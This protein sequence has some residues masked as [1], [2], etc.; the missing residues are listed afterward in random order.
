MVAAYAVPSISPPDKLS[1]EEMDV[2]TCINPYKFWL[3]LAFDLAVIAGVIA[4]NEYF[5]FNPLVY[6]FT[7]L[8]ISSRLHAFAVLMHDCAHQRAFTSKRLNEIVGEPLAW[9]VLFTREGYRNNHLA[10]HQ[11]LNTM[12]D[13]DW[14]RK[15]SYGPFTF[16]KTKPALAREM[17]RQ[18]SGGGFAWFILSLIRS[19]VT[20]DIS[21]TVKRYRLLFYIA[22][23]GIC[24]ATGTLGRLVLYW[25][26]PLATVFN[27]L[28]YQRSV[29]EHHGNMEY[30]HTYTNTR[31]I[32][33]RWWEAFIF[34]PHNVNY[35]MEHHLYPH[36]P[37]YNLPLLHRFM[38][39][40]PAYAAKAHITHGIVDGL[41]GEFCEK[42]PRGVTVAEIFE[43]QK[44][45]A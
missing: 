32:L 1:R 20:S 40:R 8:V 45:A 31:T 11:N 17:L 13:P 36:V 22:L 12:Q 21:P 2:V 34:T 33:P 23:F 14:M 42:E 5:F 38:M 6:L 28:M 9:I 43:K 24:I 7:V 16:P 44:A 29:S 37:F 10:H 18:I 30:D 35:H 26:V 3:A 39:Q 27:L 25:L 41:W 4:L 19:K 15:T